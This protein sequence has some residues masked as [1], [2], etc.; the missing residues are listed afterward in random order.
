[1]ASI[2]T[3]G[4]GFISF[5]Q[6][7]AGQSE[8]GSSGHPVGAGPGSLGHWSV[9]SGTSSPSASGGVV[10]PPLEGKDKTSTNAFLPVAVLPACTPIS[11]GPEGAFTTNVYG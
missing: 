9:E 11:T 4:P 2:S 5:S 3:P 8:G 6:S 1:M 10:E 7:E